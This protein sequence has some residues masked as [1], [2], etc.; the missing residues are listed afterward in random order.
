M[1]F[2][3]VS[4]FGAM[5][6]GVLGYVVPFLFVLTI[7]VFFHELGHLLIARWCGVKSSRFQSDLAANWSA[8][9]TGT[10]PGGRFQPFPS[11]VM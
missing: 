3:F 6:W 5:G 8:S 11:A 1:N 2:D 9:M 4:N 10:E 7:V